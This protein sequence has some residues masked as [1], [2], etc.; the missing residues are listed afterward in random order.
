MTKDNIIEYL[1]YKLLKFRIEQKYI[2]SYK[3]CA[4][5]FRSG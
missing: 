5:Y 2:R 3:K 1:K 4:Y